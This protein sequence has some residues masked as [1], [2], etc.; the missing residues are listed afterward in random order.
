MC[1][2]NEKSDILSLQLPKQNIKGTYLH[3]TKH[4]IPITIKNYKVTLSA[5]AC[6]YACI[7]LLIRSVQEKS[8][9]CYFHF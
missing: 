9:T 3:H 5:T 6:D 1:N 2:N 8:D 4:I 7:Y